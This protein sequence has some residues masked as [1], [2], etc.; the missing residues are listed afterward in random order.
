MHSNLRPPDVARVVLGF[1]YEVHNAPAYKFDN[2]TSADPQPLI[3][4]IEPSA[5]ELLYCYTAMNK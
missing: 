4:R 1:I 3:N 2:V 5:A